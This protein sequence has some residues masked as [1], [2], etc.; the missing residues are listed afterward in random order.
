MLTS[1]EI[2]N[3]KE[4]LQK[5]RKILSFYEFMLF[6][7]RYADNIIDHIEEGCFLMVHF[8]LEILFTK[9]ENIFK[10]IEIYK[11]LTENDL[12][13]AYKNLSYKNKIDLEIQP[14]KIILMHI[15]LG[16]KNG[17]CLFKKHIIVYL[18]EFTH[19]FMTGK[20]L[21]LFI[22]DDF[23]CIIFLLYHYIYDDSMSLQAD[24]YLRIGNALAFLSLHNYH[25]S[26]D[27]NLSFSKIMNH[28]SQ[29][30]YII[31]LHAILRH[32]FPKC[33]H[34]S[35]FYPE[36]F[37]NVGNFIENI[38]TLTE[39][40]DF[41]DSRIKILSFKFCIKYA[42]MLRHLLYS[43]YQYE[44]MVLDQSMTQLYNDI[45]SSFNEPV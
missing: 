12:S 15:Y 31:T 28:I 19:L 33:I 17:F 1:L 30:S 20:I 6:K 37:T 34:F 21:D 9:L 11:K 35:A 32:I 10:K 25:T 27:I 18:L 26:Q 43:D 7:Y 22:N 2:Q 24:L 36:L 40:W 38:S 14:L 13:K 44:K 8:L 29:E 5:Y 4:E 39:Q 41:L 42:Y 16:L 23:G 3:V 45:S